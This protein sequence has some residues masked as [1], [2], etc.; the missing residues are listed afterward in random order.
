MF[1]TVF[2]AAAARH[3]YPRWLGSLSVP[4]LRLSPGLWSEFLALIVPYT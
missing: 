3:N 4:L 2:R 1:F